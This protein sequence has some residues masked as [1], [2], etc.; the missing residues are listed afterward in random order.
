MSEPSQIFSSISRDSV[1]RDR[2]MSPDFRRSLPIALLRARE[3]IM[4]HFRPMLASHDV[5][6]Q[7]WRVIR[8]LAEA[9]TLD[10]S[11]VAEKAFILAPSLTRMIKSLEER[12]YITRQ[13]DVGDGRRILLKLA[14]AGVDILRTITP[15]S[16]AIYDSIEARYG[17]L[18]VEHLVDLLD[19]L[20]MLKSDS[21][22]DD[23][24]PH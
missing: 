12:G 3:A 6:E 17:K 4:S 13:K 24:Q 1:P 9:G 11:E 15:D 19:E 20:A 21:P 10:A 2:L 16:L 18:R 14:P 8:I 22:S 5:T 23:Q 7:Q